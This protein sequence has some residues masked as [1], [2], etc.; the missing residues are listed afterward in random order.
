[1]TYQ[2]F[3]GRNLCSDA[4][5]AHRRLLT[6]NGYP[7]SLEYVTGELAVSSSA[8]SSIF[9]DDA[10]LLKV[11]IESALMQLHDRCIQATTAVEDDNPIIQLE[12]LAV[13]YVG[14]ALD[15]SGEFLAL[16]S[17]TLGALREDDELTRFERAVLEL[18]Q[19]LLVRARDEGL[20][21]SRDD[22]E[23][24]AEL[25]SSY[26]CGA[27]HR[28]MLQRLPQEEPGP[29]DLLGVCK[30]LRLLLQRLIG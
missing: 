26:I 6:R 27:V 16:R 7:P 23:V 1:M 30:N 19:R 18:L 9:H 28:V 4:I 8:L 3:D 21:A 12:A 24:L 17:T 29:R 25:I 5:R 14:W 20:L 11:V 2:D 10:H 15:H 13:A 22:P